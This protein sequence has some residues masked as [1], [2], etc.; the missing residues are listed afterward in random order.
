MKEALLKPGFSLVEAISP[1]PTGFGR[2]HK[3]REGLD[4]LRYYREHGIID[5]KAVLR[6]ATIELGGKLVEGNFVNIEKPTFMQ[7]R[8][9]WLR[10]HLEG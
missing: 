6:E 3:Q 1:C 10:E 8:E 9:R 7:Q 4:T 2:R 5:H